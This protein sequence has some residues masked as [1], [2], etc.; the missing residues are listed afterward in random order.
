VKQKKCANVSMR[1]ERERRPTVAWVELVG[2]LTV[3]NCTL[4]TANF[5][6]EARQQASTST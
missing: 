6:R 1:R 4:T 2:A 5:Y 3:P